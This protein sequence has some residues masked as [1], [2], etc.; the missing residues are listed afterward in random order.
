MIADFLKQYWYLIISSVITIAMIVLFIISSKQYT[1]QYV[2]K[3]TKVGSYLNKNSLPFITNLYISS[4]NDK[5]DINC[6]PGFSKMLVAQQTQLW[7]NS[8]SSGTLNTEGKSPY[9]YICYK[10]GTNVKEDTPVLT[11]IKLNNTGGYVDNSYKCCDINGNEICYGNY[12]DCVGR[13][14]PSEMT[15]NNGVCQ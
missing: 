8:D 10:T 5:N 11:D 6:A 7:N 2:S 13:C 1:G 3:G 4:S 14:C 12:M 15:C 9:V